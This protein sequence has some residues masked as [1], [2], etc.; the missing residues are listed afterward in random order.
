M[1]SK[2]KVTCNGCFDGLHPG[3]LFFLGFALSKGDRLV[4]GINSGD[5]IKRVKKRDPFFTEKE[6]IEML[7]NLE[8]IE[9]VEIFNEDTPIEFLLREHPDIHCNGEEYGEN[10]IEAETLKKMGSQLVLI[11]RLGKWSTGKCGKKM[12]EL[13]MDA[14]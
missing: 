5:Y 13:L 2:I 9:R 12:I 11:P 8:I 4:V 10:C 7:M 14:Q 6:R 1:K 3:Q